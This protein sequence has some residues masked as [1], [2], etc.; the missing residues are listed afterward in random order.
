MSAV[1][2][3]GLGVEVGTENQKICNDTKNIVFLVIV[4]GCNL[5]TCLNTANEHA[6]F[7]GILGAIHM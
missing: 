5:V 3:G 2:K 7:R 4:C 1:V 6:Q